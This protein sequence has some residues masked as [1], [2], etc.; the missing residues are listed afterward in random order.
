[1]THLG[2]ASR[3]YGP[4]APSLANVTDVRGVQRAGISLVTLVSSLAACW[5]APIE[6]QAARAVAL[7]PVAD[8]YVSASAPQGRFGT[9]SRLRVDASPTTRSYLRFTVPRLGGPIRRARLLVWGRTGSRRGF[10]VRPVARSD[11]RER[12]LTFANRPRVRRVASRSAAVRSG[13]RIA[14][15]VSSLVVRKG[16]V[17]LAL[18]AL[19][20][21]SVTLASRESGRRAPRLSLTLG[22]RRTPAGVSPKAPPPP[23]LGTQPAFP[24]RATFYYP[25]F[26]EAW[27]Q[28][29]IYPFTKSIP[30]LGLYRSD[31]ASVI[32]SHIRSMEH[33]KIEAA[34]FSWWGQGTKEDTRLGPMLRTID[35]LGSSLRVAPY[36][37]DEGNGPDPGV[38][39]LRS[40][41]IYIK[42]SYAAHPAYLKV[43]GKPVIFAYGDGGDGCAMADRW[44]RANA[45]IGFYIVLKVF[46]DYRTCASQPDSWHQYAPARAT[47]HQPGHAYGIAPGFWLTSEPSPR[48]TRDPARWA[49]N[50]R[51][52]VASGA[53][54]QLVLTFN[55][56]GESSAVESAG[57]WRSATGQG[58]YLDALRTDGR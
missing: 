44:R 35:E 15:D 41:L 25:W 26:P 6:S 23:G 27:R 22:A 19:G 39:Q 12:T 18:T 2:T 50:V 8:A 14:V 58:I 28:R 49:R 3:P 20:G 29:G 42:S 32:G 48:L 1:M 10:A 7:R 45:G 17:S 16:S 9:S 56:W 30:S 34:I 57:D 51:D 53:P 52:M 43:D 24:I 46:G 5:A 36:H 37:E 21:R 38:D 40:D 4:A 33:A 54:W 47:D 55:E 31:V 13:R 11:W